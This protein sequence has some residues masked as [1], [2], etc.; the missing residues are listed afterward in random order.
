MARKQYPHRRRNNNEPCRAVRVW[1]TLTEK[2][3]Q[4]YTEYARRDGETLGQW[5]SGCLVQ[6]IEERILGILEVEDD[7]TELQK[8]KMRL[9][10][11]NQGEESREHHN[12]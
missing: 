1:T 2:E 6:G 5:L 10:D 7:D 11:A 12:D 4:Q 3:E 9:A 8:A